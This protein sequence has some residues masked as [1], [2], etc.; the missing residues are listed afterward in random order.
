MKLNKCLT[1]WD[2]CIPQTQ[3]AHILDEIE[4]KLPHGKKYIYKTYYFAQEQSDNLLFFFNIPLFTRDCID[5]IFLFQVPI[6]VMIRLV[7]WLTTS[8]MTHT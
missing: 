1:I 4:K 5:V 3:R 8:R 6:F 7:H 2:Y